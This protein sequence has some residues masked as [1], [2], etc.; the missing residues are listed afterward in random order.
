MPSAERS[1]KCNAVNDVPEWVLRASEHWFNYCNIGVEMR[2]A[3]EQ[4]Q[5]ENKIKIFLNCISY[6]RIFKE[7]AGT[8]TTDIQQ[9]EDMTNLAWTF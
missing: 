4:V 5:K 6:P 7:L 9:V 2:A 3:H 8:S 1:W